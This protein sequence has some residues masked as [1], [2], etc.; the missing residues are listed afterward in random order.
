MKFLNKNR[1]PVNDKPIYMKGDKDG[2]EAEIALQWNDGYGET[3]YSFAN[4]INTQEGGDA[5]LGL[6]GPR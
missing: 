6:S 5:P 2:I 4:N 3:V 1:A